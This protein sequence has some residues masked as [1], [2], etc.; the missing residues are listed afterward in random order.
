MSTIQKVQS[1]VTNRL[2]ARFLFLILIFSIVGLWVSPEGAAAD[3][4]G[5][6][7]ESP[8]VGV[9]GAAEVS[10]AHSL[11]SAGPTLSPPSNSGFPLC[12]LDVFCPN[13]GILEL[14]AFCFLIL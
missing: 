2:S 13:D 11:F 4:G 5:V 3:D 7:G 9:V 12:E 14:D 8:E 6:G 1:Q 10:S